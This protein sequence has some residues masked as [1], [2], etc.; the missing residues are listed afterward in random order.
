MSDVSGSI[1][2]SKILPKATARRFA[3]II[4][5]DARKRKIWP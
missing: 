2:L 3:V 5:K 4:I 1:V